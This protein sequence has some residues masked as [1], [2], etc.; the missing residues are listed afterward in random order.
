MS[1]NRVKESTSTTGTGSFTTTG[2]FS[3]FETFNTA[4]GLN[5]RFPYWAVNKTNNQREAG[6]GYLSG[7]TTLVRETILD[8][9]SGGSGAPTVVNFTTAPILFSE[10]SEN[11]KMSSLGALAS[12][13]KVVSAHIAT[14]Y[15]VNV[16]LTADRVYYIPMHPSFEQDIDTLGVTCG[17]KVGTKIRLGIYENNKGVVGK[18]IS[19]TADITPVTD[20]YVSGSITRIRLQSDWYFI[21]IAVDAAENIYAY[22]YTFVSCNPLGRNGGLFN[23]E[24]GYA[25]EDSASWTALPANGSGAT[26]SVVNLDVPLITMEIA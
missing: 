5:K 4:Y 8:D 25:H 26:I 24:F 6:I 2:A 18:V 19:E 22:P 20:T 12:G 7:T 21:A 17:T 14:G 13:T 16:A 10:D 1:A 23:W 15:T 3:N 11:S 9:G